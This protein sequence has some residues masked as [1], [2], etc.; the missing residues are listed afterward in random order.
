MLFTMI[1]KNACGITSM[2]RMSEA[3][4]KEKCIENMA[5]ALGYDTLEELPHYDTI[6]DF[7][8]RLQPMELERI[9][10]F[11]IKELLKKGV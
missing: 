4:N 11:M 3:F 5:V 10:D 1:M 9:R 7:L 8:C 6:N 2:G